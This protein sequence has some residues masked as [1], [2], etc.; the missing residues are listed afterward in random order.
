M[1]VQRYVQEGGMCLSLKEGIYPGDVGVCVCQGGV[2][3]RG[4]VCQGG[5]YPEEDVLEGVYLGGVYLG[6]VFLGGVCLG[7]VYPGVSASVGGCLSWGEGV[8]PEGCLPRG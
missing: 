4:N 5:V 7:G 6:G 8:C 2:S 3:S 1:S